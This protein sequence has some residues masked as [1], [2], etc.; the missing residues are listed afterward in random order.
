MIVCNCSSQY[1]TERF[2][3][4]CCYP[5]DNVTAQ[6]LSVGQKALLNCRQQLTTTRRKNDIPRLTD[7]EIFGES[8]FFKHSSI[9]AVT[10]TNKS[11]KYRNNEST[12]GT[13]YNATKWW[14]S[15]HTK[16][17]CCA[18]EQLNFS[19]ENSLNS[20]WKSLILSFVTSQRYP[21]PSYTYYDYIIW[22]T[23]L[24]YW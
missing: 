23:W 12:V 15:C 7:S 20:T 14:E 22:V 11:F 13:D 16:T 21:A 3:R 5:P 17:R 24:W 9:A 1:S 19:P 6:M 10:H 18:S 8:V 4:S 2:R